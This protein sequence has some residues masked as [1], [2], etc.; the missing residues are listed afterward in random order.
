MS[1]EEKINELEIRR[2]LVVDDKPENIAAAKQYF[3]ALEQYG[4]KVEYAQSAK[5]AEEMI[6][7]A[8]QAKDKYSI[9]LSDLEMESPKCGL[10]VIRQAI[11]YLAQG[12][13]VSGFDG[14]STGHGMYT[15]I[16]PKKVLPSYIEGT[17]QKA[18]VWEKAFEAVIKHIAT[19]GKALFDSTER[20]YRLLK[21]EVTLTDYLVTSGMYPF[22][23]LAGLER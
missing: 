10:D 6:K 4:V 8:F 21:K 7:S 2:I 15:K 9:V 5:Q 18:W 14:S 22:R 16:Y 13:I 17:K 23:E 1:L 19:E 20:F 11:E 12:F 3:G